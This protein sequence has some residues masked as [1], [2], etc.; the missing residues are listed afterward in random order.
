MSGISGY[1]GISDSFRIARIYPETP[2]PLDISG[3]SGTPGHSVNSGPPEYLESPEY[4]AHPEDPEIPVSPGKT[5]FPQN[6]KYNIQK[7]MTKYLV[8]SD[9]IVTFVANKKYS[10]KNETTH[11]NHHRTCSAIITCLRSKEIKEDNRD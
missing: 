2:E 7:K 4:P 8:V 9:I 1:S 10:S 3:N 6:A 5:L 11:N